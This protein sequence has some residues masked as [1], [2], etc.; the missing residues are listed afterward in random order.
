MA[1]R[2]P[3]KKSFDEAESQGDEAKTV[4][5]VERALS[6]IEALADEGAPMHLG[7]LANKVDLKPSTAHRLL[8]T[9]MT[10]GFVDQDDQSRYK[11]GMKLYYIGATATYAVDV[12][13]LA[14][15]Y[16]RDLLDRYNET[17]NLAILD[18]GEVVYVDQLE[19]NNI[20]VVRMFAKVGSRGPAHCTG[21][22][23]ALLAGLTDE[24]LAE[25]LETAD[26]QRFT[27]DTITDPKVLARELQRVRSDGFALDLC[28]R[29]EGV[30]CVAAPIKNH[31]GRVVAAISVSGPSMRMTTAYINQELISVVTDTARKISEKMGYKGE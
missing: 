31:E 24:E 3:A 28:E 6:I 22:G 14:S 23:K 29:D 21:S 17:V 26:L 9:L 8:G 18:R 1:T 4:Q 19:S 2:I 27:N 20:V 15:P 13:K 10:R 16:M 25:Y 7:D 12:R 30:R 5:S 11:L